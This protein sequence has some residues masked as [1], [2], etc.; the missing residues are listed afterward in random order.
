M[1]YLILSIVVLI[2][3]GAAV[4]MSASSKRGWNLPGD[5]LDIRHEQENR[6]DGE[7]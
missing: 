1:E 2:P 4:F 6:K 5:E 7:T 3:I